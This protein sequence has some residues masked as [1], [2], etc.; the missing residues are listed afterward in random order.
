MPRSPAIVLV[1]SSLSPTECLLA[2]DPHAH[3]HLM[4]SNQGPRRES[5]DNWSGK[6]K[7]AILML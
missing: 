5:K 7:R 6:I 1:V 4:D 2:V 3:G